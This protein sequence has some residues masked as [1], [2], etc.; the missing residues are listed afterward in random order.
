[1]ESFQITIEPAKG[2]AAEVG[3]FFASI[4][5]ENPDEPL[6][7]GVTR[8]ETTDRGVVFEFAKPAPLA[9]REAGRSQVSCVLY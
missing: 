5:A 3:E 2:S 8:M 9:L 1:A 4:K 6:W 7:Q